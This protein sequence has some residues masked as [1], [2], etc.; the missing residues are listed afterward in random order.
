MKRITTLLALF[1][2]IL[3]PLQAQPAQVQIPD[4]TVNLKDFGAVADGQTLNTSI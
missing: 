3:L 4:V 2:L 1:C